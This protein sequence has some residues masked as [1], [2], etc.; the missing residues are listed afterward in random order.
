MLGMPMHPKVKLYPGLAS[1]NPP[2]SEE[3]GSL[4][5]SSLRRRGHERSPM[6][7]MGC[8]PACLSCDLAGK[9]FHT[10]RPR[11]RVVDDQIERWLK[12][13]FAEVQDGVLLKGNADGSIGQRAILARDRGR[14]YHSV[15]AGRWPYA[16][17]N[18][19]GLHLV[20]AERQ[21]KENARKMA[22]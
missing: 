16:S 17:I 13:C 5:I 8:R 9:S 1:V 3:I 11:S 2:I 20:C 4:N 19:K 22:G 12:H 18:T 10:M 7:Y 14:G 15:R 21:M 6:H